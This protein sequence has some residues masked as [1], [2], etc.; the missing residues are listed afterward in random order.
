MTIFEQALKLA[1][2]E[3]TAKRMADPPERQLVLNAVFEPASP[4]SIGNEPVGVLPAVEGTMNHDIAKLPAGLK[5]AMLERPANR[6][7]SDVDSKCSARTIREAGRGIDNFQLFPRRRQPFKRVRLGMPLEKF[8]RRYVEV[9][10]F[11]ERLRH[12]EGLLRLWPRRCM[13]ILPFGGAAGDFARRRGNSPVELQLR[14]GPCRAPQRGCLVSYHADGDGREQSFHFVFTIE[15][16]KEAA[17][18]QH[19]QNPY[20][21]SASDEDASA[22][23]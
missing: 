9:G 23:E 7:W 4:P 18:P 8:L 2:G 13:Q 19:G 10:L 15:S 12:L 14:G 16:I 3:P 22:S 5:I 11:D 21:D 1:A 6:E 17:F 20:G